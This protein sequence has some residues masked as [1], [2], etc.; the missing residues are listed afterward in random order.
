V[1]TLARASAAAWSQNWHLQGPASL[2]LA[3]ISVT[4]SVRHQ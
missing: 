4:S 3:Q 1:V 2:C